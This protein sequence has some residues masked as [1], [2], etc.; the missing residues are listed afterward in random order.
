LHHVRVQVI[1]FGQCWHRFALR[2]LMPVQVCSGRHGRTQKF[3]P[4][5]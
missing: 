5:I 2:W 4:G 1:L 3:H